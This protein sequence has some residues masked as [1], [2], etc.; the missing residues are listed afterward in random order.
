M[1][2]FSNRV[3]TKDICDR[4]ED[5]K[6]IPNVSAYLLNVSMY[7]KDPKYQLKDIGHPV[8]DLRIYMYKMAAKNVPSRDR[9]F[10]KWQDIATTV[11]TVRAVWGANMGTRESLYR[12]A[13]H[14]L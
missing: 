3:P 8:W 13:V 4:Y 6:R 12:L 11:R 2:V 9:N 5:S 10:W 1:F 14:T 7:T